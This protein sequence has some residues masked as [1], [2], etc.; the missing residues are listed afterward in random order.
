[1]VIQLTTKVNL[2][3]G[4]C[5]KS[6][7]SDPDEAEVPFVAFRQKAWLTWCGRLKSVKPRLFG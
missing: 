2:E 1:M 5:P 3:S 4:F 7:N 6:R